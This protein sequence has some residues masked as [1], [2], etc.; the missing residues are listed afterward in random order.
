[1]RVLEHGSA[2]CLLRLI[3]EFDQQEITGEIHRE[4]AA[5]GAL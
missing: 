4:H 3:R 5:I 2:A 1:V